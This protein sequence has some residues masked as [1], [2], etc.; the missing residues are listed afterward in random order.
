[1]KYTINLNLKKPDLLELADVD[2]LNQNSDALD[3]VVGN[4]ITDMSNI[5][6]DV[7]GQTIKA[8]NLYNRLDS[9]F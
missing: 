4:L 6:S 5:K 7:S 8:I 2:V 3:L 9:I 1:M